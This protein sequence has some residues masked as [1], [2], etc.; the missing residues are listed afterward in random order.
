MTTPASTTPLYD[1]CHPTL[2]PRDLLGQRV[3]LHY[4]QRIPRASAWITGVLQPA[5]TI[6]PSL[7]MVVFNSDAAIRFNPDWAVVLAHA[8]GD[9]PVIDIIA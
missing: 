7:L 9:L 3:R 5:G 6:D 2:K 8:P 1:A 4:H